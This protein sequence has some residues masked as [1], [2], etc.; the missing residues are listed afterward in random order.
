M[1]V[2]SYGAVY[3]DVNCHCHVWWAHHVSVESLYG[4]YTFFRLPD[5]RSASSAI[6]FPSVCSEQLMLLPS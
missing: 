1:G 6:T 5:D 2:Q 3:A 4:T